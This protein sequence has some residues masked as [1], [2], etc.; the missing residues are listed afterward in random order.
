MI[1]ACLLFVF[2]LVFLC[3]SFAERKIGPLLASVLM[4]NLCALC[5]LEGARHSFVQINS[6]AGDVLILGFENPV[7]YWRG[8]MKVFRDSSANETFPRYRDENGERL[9]REWDYAIWDDLEKKKF[10]ER[11]GK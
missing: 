10:L 4:A 5:M 8:P 6:Q 2:S 7:G 9:G 1:L 3:I 11:I